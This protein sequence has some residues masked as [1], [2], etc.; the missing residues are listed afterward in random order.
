[1]GDSRCSALCRFKS[2]ERC[3]SKNPLLHDQYVQFL[4]EYASL[5]HMELVD[6]EH[7]I[8]TNEYF[9]PHHAAEKLD[10]VSTKLPV[11]FDG[12]CRT[13]NELSL[14]EVLLKGPTVQQELI[15]ILARFRTICRY[16]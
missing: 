16:Y 13:F 9:L 1:L 15:C 7:E 10:S 12:S 11:V 4:Q 3:F 14:N 2:L 5:G 8:N 6:I